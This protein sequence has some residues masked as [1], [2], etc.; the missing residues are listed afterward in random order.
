MNFKNEASRAVDHSLNFIKDNKGEVVRL[1]CLWAVT[2]VSLR[3]EQA[4]FLEEC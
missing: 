2:C 4:V 3:D 1:E